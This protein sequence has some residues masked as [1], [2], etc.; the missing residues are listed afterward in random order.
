MESIAKNKNNKKRDVRL[1]IVRIFSLFCVIAVH[2]F[3]NSGFYEKAVIGKKYVDI[4][5]YKIILYNMCTNVYYFNR[6]FNE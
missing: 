6:I 3:L 2:F 5:Y 1:D 4:K